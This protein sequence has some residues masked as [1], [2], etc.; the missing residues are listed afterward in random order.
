MDEALSVALSDPPLDKNIDRANKVTAAAT[1]ATCSQLSPVKTGT[2]PLR[3][4]AF[5]QGNTLDSSRLTAWLC[6]TTGFCLRYRDGGDQ[7]DAGR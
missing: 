1:F 7:G 3:I 5:L 6:V 2:T 4:P